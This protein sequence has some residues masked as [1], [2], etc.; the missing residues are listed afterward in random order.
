MRDNLKEYEAVAK[1][2]ENIVRSVAD[3]DSKYAK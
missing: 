2:A 1:A 3:G